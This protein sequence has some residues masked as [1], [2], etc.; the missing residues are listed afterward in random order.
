MS[1]LKGKDILD[2]AQFTR[3]E[4][5]AI[6]ALADDYRSQLAER[7][8]LDVLKGA[9][10]AALFFEPSTRTRLSFETAMHRLGGAVVGFCLCRI[11]LGC[12]G[13]DARRHHPH[14]R[15]IRRRDRDAAPAHRLGPRGR[16]SGER[17][18][19]ERR[20]RRGPAPDPGP[21]RPVYDPPGARQGRR[22]NDRA[23]GR[24]EERPHRPC[25][26]RDLQAL[27]LQAGLR[28]ARGAADAARGRPAPARRA[29]SRWR[30]PTAW[31]PRCP[32]RTSST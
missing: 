20:R 25:R 26:R 30:R 3:E 27:Q 5:D 1:S 10:L 15:P 32:R 8:G 14:G 28:R 24:P 11:D 6:M 17:A 9:V 13:R 22:P 29:A 7:R 31:K 21:A 4:I 23:G 16:G 12:Q 18:G 2:G 19:A